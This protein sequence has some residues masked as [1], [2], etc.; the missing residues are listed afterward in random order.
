VGGQ[1]FRLDG[2]ATVPSDLAVFLGLVLLDAP[3]A[4]AQES[5]HTG[6]LVSEVPPPRLFGKGEEFGGVRQKP[7]LEWKLV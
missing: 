7:L 6:R 4:D 1:V 5:A 2:R 3:S